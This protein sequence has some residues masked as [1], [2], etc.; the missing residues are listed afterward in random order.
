MASF[1][2]RTEGCPWL[3]DENGVELLESLM[4]VVGESL[5]EFREVFRIDSMLT[6]ECRFSEG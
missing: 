2:L 3:R 6:K 5:E 1:L 4:E